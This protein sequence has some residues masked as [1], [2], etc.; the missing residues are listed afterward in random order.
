MHSTIN[1]TWRPFLTAALLAVGV[2]SN[3]DG[4]TRAEEIAAEQAK[5]AQALQPYTPTRP[6]AV[7]S[8]IE[9]R[10][11]YPPRFAVTL[12]SVYSGGGFTLGA[13]YHEPMGDRAFLTGRGL[14]SIK[15]Y[16]LAEFGVV[17]PGHAGER[18]DLS[19]RAG[20]RD[21]TQVGYFGQG[22][23]TD[24]DDRANYRFKETYLEGGLTFRPARW[25][26]LDARVSYEDWQLESGKGSAPSIE[27]VYTPATAPGLGQ[28][29][30][31]LH[32]DL[33]AAVDWRYPGPMYARRGGFYGVAYNR[34]DD[35][36]DA[37]SFDRVDVELI[38]HVPIWRETWVL[39]LRTRV[40]S[41]IGDDDVVP[42]F[43]LPSLGGG[44]SL[45]AYTAFRYRD[46]HSLLA[47]A[48]WRWIPNNVGLDM[49]LFYDAGKVASRRSALDFSNLT[50]NWGIGARFH[51]PLATVLRIEAAKGGEGW[52]LV[53]STSAPF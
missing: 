25:M 10:L 11:M 29:P 50:S 14:L 23:D 28:S 1:H 30:T 46:R 27:T 41:T 4:Q 49:A 36:D 21:A 35:S 40:Q 6:E 7:L 24:K 31:Y 32:T 53:F 33:R 8:R 19:A 38:Q 44:H 12:D 5:K 45:R 51:G 2:S 18:L 20:W 42:Y 26:P 48:E 17:S 47:S 22:N 9:G 3:A 34:Y 16:K 13:L 15:L 39:S 37:L 43:M 52:H